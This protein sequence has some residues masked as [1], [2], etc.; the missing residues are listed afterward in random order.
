MYWLATF[1][2]WGS[3]LEYYLKGLEP[4]IDIDANEYPRAASEALIKFKSLSV[5]FQKL[6]DAITAAIDHVEDT[7]MIEELD[8]SFEE[9]PLSM[10]P[11]F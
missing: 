7:R 9:F 11:H 4:L 5:E 3:Q 2:D 6:K 8:K 1:S 10:P